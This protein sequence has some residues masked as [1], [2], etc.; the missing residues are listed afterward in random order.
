VSP[1]L[2]AAAGS[3]PGW[4]TPPVL[5]LTLDGAP[6]ARAWGQALLAASVRQELSTPAVCELRFA[7]PEAERRPVAELGA[8]LEVALPTA[9]GR[10]FAG[11]VE[12]VELGL[13]PAGGRELLVRAED[14]L[15]ALRSRQPLRRFLDLTPADFARELVGG[16][17]R[18]VRA[19]DEGA[20]IT[21]F[22][23]AG[24][25]DLATLG[26]LC[27]RQGLYFQLDGEALRLFRLA[28][29]GSP[30]VL[31]HGRNLL[32]AH[33]ER[34]RRGTVARVAALAWEVGSAAG[35]QAAAEGGGGAGEA[36]L[37]GLASDGERRTQGSAQA[38]L[39]RRAAAGLVLEA[40]A[41]GDVGLV[42]GRRLELAGL[43]EGFAGP[44]VAIVVE[45]RF[46][47][48]RG[49]L[50]Q[51]STRPPAPRAAAEPLQ[52]TLGT[53][54]RVADPE[55][56]GRVAVVMPALGGLETLWLP[57]LS[58]AAGPAKGLVT[59][60]NVDDAVLVLLPA[61]DP[62]LGLVLGGLWGLAEAPLAAVEAGETRRLGLVSAAGQRLVLDDAARTLTVRD[63]LG[64]ELHLGPE[65]CRLRSEGDLELAAPGRRLVLRA[66][67]IDFERG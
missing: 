28:G 47:P 1:Q 39:E 43:P 11:S 7:W 67:Q 37:T 29:W 24:P 30:L 8:R 65:G 60:P 33:L 6:L 61:G 55:G 31:E 9:G 22:F 21:A 3:T 17:V 13:S 38:E 57:V 63:A 20:P 59:L 48:E 19:E 15:A 41:Q 32:E 23:Q 14:A 44:I 5:A 26:T 49:Y 56:R 52:L 53:V 36:S 34:S 2:N 66:E 16:L 64:S 62:S 27:E 51:L 45:H 18:E 54:S 58:P 35:Q 12:E 42:P 10:L 4:T 25:S 50:C 40:V 46:T